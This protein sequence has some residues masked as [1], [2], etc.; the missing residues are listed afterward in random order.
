MTNEI[1]KI[2]NKEMV[3]CGEP[4]NSVSGHYCFRMWAPYSCYHMLCIELGLSIQTEEAGLSYT[5]QGQEKE[6]SIDWVE[7]DLIIAFKNKAIA[8][9]VLNYEK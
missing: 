5:A 1:K 2:L 8:E 4:Y 7:H 9:E 6:Y 3:Y